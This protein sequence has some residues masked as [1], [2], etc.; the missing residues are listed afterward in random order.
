METPN[1]RNR[2]LM[3]AMLSVLMLAVVI[4]VGN[5]VR[6]DHTPVAS[7]LA[8]DGGLPSMPAEVGVFR[9]AQKALAF[10]AMPEAP[11]NPRTLDVYYSRRAYAG[12]PPVIPHEQLNGDTYGPAPCLGCHRNGGFVPQFKAFAPIT[13]HPDYPS[14]NQC[15]VPA[16][17]R[18]AFRG[19]DF[20]AAKPPAYDQRALPG[21]PPPVPHTLDLRNNCLA[22][23]GTPAAPKEIRTTHPERVNCRQCHSSVSEPLV[24][25]FLD[26]L[27]G[28]AAW[29]R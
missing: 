20:V 11:G 8:G 14:C 29:K 24:P 18:P 19:S 28:G 17:D 9:E 26:E 6:A 15:H 10:K 23:H 27:A 12:A 22:C 25:G 16:N 2:V 21:A 13:P 4:V 5:S 3:I 7:T 1:N